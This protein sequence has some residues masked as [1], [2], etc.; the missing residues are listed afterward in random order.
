[1]RSNG[2]RDEAKA[3]RGGPGPPRRG[4]ACAARWAGR[5]ALAITA[6]APHLLSAAAGHA[7]PAAPGFSVKILDAAR[8]VDSRDLIGKKVLVVRFQASYCKPCARESAAFGRVAERYRDRGVEF[9]ALHVQDTIADTRRFARAQRAT[10]PIALDPKLTI[11]S[12]FGFKG[13]PYTVVIDAKGEMVARI[14][15]ESVVNHLTRI[16]DVQLTDT[17]PRR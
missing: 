14:H 4:A 17:P 10:Y 9:L 11:A 6:V 3:A 8:T 2:G 13:T 15:G 12:R 16:L 7:A 1:V 5:L